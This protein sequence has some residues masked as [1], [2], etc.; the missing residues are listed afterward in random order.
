MTTRPTLPL[1][2]VLLSFLGTGARPAPAD[3]PEGK[4]LDT[5]FRGKIVAFEKKG[6]TLRYDFS[7]AV[8]Q[9]DWVEGVPFPIGQAPEQGVA[10]VDGSLEER[11]F[12]AL[13]GRGER[14]TGAVAFSRPRLLMQYRRMIADGATFAEALASARANA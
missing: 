2:L 7:D 3:E 11:R 14:L 12:V 9:Q 8:Q 10:V 6:L 1:L 4:A 5:F 13:F